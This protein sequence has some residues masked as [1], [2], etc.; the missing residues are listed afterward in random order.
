M[1]APPPRPDSAAPRV[2]PVAIQELHHAVRGYIGRRVADAAAADDL[3]QD[4]FAKVVRQLPRVR[5]A[6]RLTGWIFRIARNVVTDHYRRARATTPYNEE[7]HTDGEAAT[8]VVGREEEQ[9]RQDLNHYVRR[10]IDG[11]A[12]AYR[13]ALLLTEY[14]GLSQVELAARLGLSVSAA[15]SRVQRARRMVRETMERCCHFEVDRYGDV[16]DMT[17]RTRCDC[18]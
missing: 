9:L 11:L 18:D 1:A 17:P 7:V 4:V 15:K 16:L 14:E 10:V 6:R 12:P 5:D 2:L 8:E 13:D 3:T